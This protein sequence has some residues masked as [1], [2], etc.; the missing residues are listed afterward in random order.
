MNDAPVLDLDDTAAGTGATLNYTENQ[1]PTAIAPLIALSDP[2][3][4]NFNGGI[5]NIG[6]TA[7]AS[8]G[9][10][11][12]IE[13]Q[14][15]GPGEIGVSGTTVLFGGVAIGTYAGGVN[16]GNLVVF[17]NADAATPFRCRI[18]EDRPRACADFP[19]AGAACLDA[20]R[21]V[22]LSV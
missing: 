4:G 9:D 10:Q 21:R 7:N 16:G 13:H 12:T 11:L 1:A 15:T 2:D 18:Y 3:S 8:A 5:L 17:F 20:R 6:Y 19:I 22:G 14:G